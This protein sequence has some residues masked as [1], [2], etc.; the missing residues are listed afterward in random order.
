MLSDTRV[1]PWFCL[2]SDSCFSI[3]SALGSFCNY[4]D[5]IQKH[6]S[7]PLFNG[8]QFTGTN[9]IHSLL[10][11]LPLCLAKTFSSPRAETLNLVSN[12][13]CNF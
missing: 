7:F 10:W 1:H 5:K 4:C 8:V 12:N 2:H 6:A 11:S 13:C 9:Y 3:G